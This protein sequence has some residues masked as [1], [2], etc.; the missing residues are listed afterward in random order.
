MGSKPQV[1]EWLAADWERRGLKLTTAYQGSTKKQHGRIE[2]REIWVL[3]DAELAGYAGSAARA[4]SRR[5][6]APSA[7]GHEPLRKSDGS[8]GHCPCSPL[9]VAGQ[10]DCLA[11]P[12]DAPHRPVL[13]QGVPG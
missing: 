9:G 10:V 2:R 7:V 5:H 13:R 4:T 1:P 6:Y 8:S 12:V 3:W 11:Q